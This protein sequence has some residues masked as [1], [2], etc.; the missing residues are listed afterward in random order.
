M[1]QPFFFEPT[2]ICLVMI[3]V[4]LGFPAMFF[5]VPPLMVLLVTVLAFGVEVA[6]AIIGLAAVLAVVVNGPVQV[7]F[8]LFNVVLAPGA[9][10]GV[11]QGR[12]H[13]AC[14]SECHYGCYGNF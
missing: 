12:R 7:R 2:E 9:I 1:G 14:E 4:L 10:V 11:R 6:A 8:G 3:P 5:A 13:E